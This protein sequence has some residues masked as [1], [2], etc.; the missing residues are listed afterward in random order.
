MDVNV[1][2]CLSGIHNQYCYE[3]A[4]FRLKVLCSVLA[5]PFFVGKKFCSTVFHHPVLSCSKLGYD[6]PV[7]EQNIH[8]DLRAKSK[9]SFILFQ[10][11][12]IQF[13]DWIC[14]KSNRENYPGKCFW[15]KQVKESEIKCN[16]CFVLMGLQTTGPRGIKI[17]MSTGNILSGGDPVMD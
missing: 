15:K 11:F 8:S 14:S 3:S 4:W 10:S 17:L 9:L 16:P 2:L 7:S 5:V 6:N 1:I 12:C 13:D